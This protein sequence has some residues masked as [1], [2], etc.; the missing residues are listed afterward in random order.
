MANGIVKRDFDEATDSGAPGEGALTGL[1]G[2]GIGHQA[3]AAVA[4]NYLDNFQSNFP[5]LDAF[6]GELNAVQSG[7]TSQADLQRDGS[8]INATGS[9]CLRVPAGGFRSGK[10]ATGG[11]RS[12]SFTIESIMRK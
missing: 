3:T 9:T 5:S 1:P 12:S 6:L 4:D 10:S 2:V 7:A 8:G 11:L